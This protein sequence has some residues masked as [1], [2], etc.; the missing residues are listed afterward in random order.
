[1]NRLLASIAPLLSGLLLIAH[2]GC[3]GSSS[4]GG[5]RPAVELSAA[6]VVVTP[7][8][9]GVLVLRGTADTDALVEVSGLP[10]G[11]TSSVTEAEGADIRLRIEAELT[12]LA[13]ESTLSIVVE[14]GGTTSER[15][16]ELSVQVPD[17]PDGV[18]AYA[19][20]VEGVVQT[21]ELDGE[22]VEVEVI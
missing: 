5:T 2:G 13:G 21:V 12:A 19:P 1:M 11:V 6:R 4:A 17:I 3:G 10:Q 16:V 22:Q 14:S 7:G 20:G 18:E 9:G 15:D 8:N